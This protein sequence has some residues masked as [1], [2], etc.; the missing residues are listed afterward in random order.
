[1]GEYAVRISDGAEIKIGTCEEMLYLRFSQRHLV[2]QKQNS[3]DVN[4]DKIAG[5]L[6]FRLPFSDEDNVLPWRL[7]EPVP[8]IQALRFGW[9]RVSW[10]RIG[11]L[12]RNH[13]TNP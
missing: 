1:M 4:D 11:R 3:L 2:R 6:F 10:W 13:A 12:P 5:L 7:C 8:A 9:E